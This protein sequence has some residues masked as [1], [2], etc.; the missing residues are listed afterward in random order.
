MESEN[1]KQHWDFSCPFIHSESAA[2]SKVLSVLII[3]FRTAFCLA[4]S[5]RRCTQAF[6]PRHPTPSLARERPWALWS[7][8]PPTAH[9]ITEHWAPKSVVLRNIS[10]QKSVKMRQVHREV[11]LKKGSCENLVTSQKTQYSPFSDVTKCWVKYIT[12]QMCEVF[13]FW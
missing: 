4:S 13:F 1:F 8:N 5:D 9:P 6:L 3:F 12:A 7:P 11:F 2:I 10:L